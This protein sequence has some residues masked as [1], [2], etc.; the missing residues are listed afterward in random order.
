[1]LLNVKNELRLFYLK[2]ESIARGVEWVRRRGSSHLKE[3]CIPDIQKLWGV[4]CYGVWIVGPN[5]AVWSC[6][7][8]GRWVAKPG[9][10]MRG[11]RSTYLLVEGLPGVQELTGSHIACIT[12]H[13]VQI[14]TPII[15]Q[16][17]GSNWVE[18]GRMGVPKLPTLSLALELA[19]KTP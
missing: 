5:C 4:I 13:I 9:V 15:I 14:R 11:G 3:Q 2:L 16:W 19:I 1:M 8:Q 6:Y 17:P 12:L 7:M 10:D 18:Q